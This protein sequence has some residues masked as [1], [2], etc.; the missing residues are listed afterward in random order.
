MR[1]LF[2][3]SEAVPLAKTGGLG[4]VVSALAAALR[5]VDVDAGILLPG[6]P[7][8]LD[9]A[10]PLTALA[11]WNDLPGGPSRLLMGR[12]PHA[13]VPVLLLETPALY[14]REGTLY[15]DPDG[16]DF[17]DN[18]LRFGALCHAAARIATGRSAYPRPDV[19]HV[20]DW[21]AGLVPLF[22]RRAGSPAK[23]I[24]TV[25]NLA[26]HGSFPFDV[27]PD[28]GLDEDDLRPESVEFW[29]QLSFLKAGLVHAHRI[30]TVSKS[31]AAEILTQAFGCGFDGLLNTRRDALTHITNGI[32][33]AV[34]NPAL[35]PHLPRQYSAEDPSGKHAAKTELQHLYGL[36]VEPFA[37]IVAMGSRLT[38]QK[39]ADVAIEA[40]GRL[41]QNHPRLQAVVLGRGA[42][43]LEE[44]Y[45]MLEHDFRGRLGLHVGYDERRAHLMHAGAD[46]LLHGSRFEP[47]GLTPL[48]AMR[49]GTVPIASRV[50]GL[51]DNIVDAG[52]GPAPAPC[53]T[54]FLFDGATVDAMTAAVERALAR[55]ADPKAW[56]MLQQN[57]MR[58][59]F[60]WEQPAAR[61]AALYRSMLPQS[62]LVGERRARSERIDR[63]LPAERSAVAAAVQAAVGRI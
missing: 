59:D 13:D 24:L 40:I 49:Y 18:A 45:R 58:H 10:G 17:A 23:S 15:Q 14:A 5:R 22:M 41:L 31:Y 26:F 8:A 29:G 47:C 7:E 27:A 16:R 37:P 44:G 52:E 20:H 61:Y 35:D 55:F 34:W 12:L 32:D 43:E 42:H 28:I 4:D 39:M 36:P 62:R 50:G 21:H 25:H 33:M 60:G 3:A 9:Q 30:S 6:Y 38:T 48:Y 1:V 11:R 63:R 19:V 53:A 51:I 56:R 54:G 46:M 2:V 57:G